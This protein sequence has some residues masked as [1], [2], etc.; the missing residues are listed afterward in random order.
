[1]CDITLITGPMFAGKTTELLRQL[2]VHQEAGQKCVLIKH[3]SDNRYSAQAEVVTHDGLTAEAIECNSL[4]NMPDE[5]MSQCMASHVIGIDE[6]QF[7]EDLVEFCDTMACGYKKVIVAGLCNTHERKG[8][9]P[10]VNLF[11]FCE[12]VTRLRA[13]CKDCS[14]PA[15]FSFR[16]TNTEENLIGGSKDYKALCR[17]CYIFNIGMGVQL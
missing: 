4:T 7:F 6:G 1:M 13:V 14:K 3:A 11:P 16:L 8:F 12:K 2:K 5:D 10:I 17:E 15:D 9:K